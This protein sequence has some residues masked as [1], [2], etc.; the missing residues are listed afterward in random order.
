MPCQ[1]YAQPRAIMLLTY[2]LYRNNF[3]RVLRLLDRHVRLRPIARVNVGATARFLSYRAQSYALMVGKVKGKCFHSQYSDSTIK[4]FPFVQP[5]KLFFPFYFWTTG[6]ASYP[7]L[8][9]CVISTA[10]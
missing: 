7:S 3:F 2:V 1:Q 4:T 8:Q 5:S 9:I 10:S 6:N